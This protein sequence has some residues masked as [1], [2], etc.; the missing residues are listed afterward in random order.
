V[1]GRIGEGRQGGERDKW[2]RKGGC[3]GRKEE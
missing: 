2:R 1:E 3:E